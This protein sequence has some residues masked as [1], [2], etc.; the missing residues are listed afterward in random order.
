MSSIAED[1]QN[2]EALGYKQS[3]KRE[4]SNLATI[5]FAF[6]IMGLCSS[7]ATTFNT[8]LLLGGPA[9]VTWCWI[10]GSCMC[11][12]LGSSIAEIVSAFPT[13]GGLYTASAQLCP[14][15]HRAVVGW[16]VGWLNILGQVAGLS[17]TEF[18]LANMIWAAVSITNPNM[19]ITPGKTVGLFTA[20]LFVHGALNSLATRHLALFTRFFVF[21]NLGA[22]VVI[23]IVL[24]AMTKREDMHPAGY[25]FGSEGIVNQTG[26]W[27]NGIAFL[28]G[29]LSVQWTMTDYDAT[30][31]ISE[32][33]RRA[34]YAAPAAIFI[35][36]IGTG[37]LGWILNIVLVLCSGPLENLPGPSDSAFLEIMALRM[38]KPVALFLWVF[39]C[40]T[41]FFVCQTALQACSRT[42]YAFSRD[43][44]LP[45]N[46]YFGHVAKQTHTPLRAIWLTTILSILPG[47][48]DLA[49]PVAADAI[50]ALTAMALD[51][52]Y[53]IPI[54]LRR[55]YANHPEVHFRP[56]PFYMGSGFL[57]WA[58]N[59]MCI[60]WTLFVCVIFSLPNVLPVTKTNMNYA[61]VITAGVVILSGAWYIASAH[62]HY[63]GPTSN[64]SHDPKPISGAGLGPDDDIPNFERDEDDSKSGHVQTYSRELDTKD[65]DLGARASGG[66][67]V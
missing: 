66:R 52:S 51:L 23:V 24:L 67:S 64:I 1:E 13:C 11:F 31:H 4:F 63:H 15:S 10:I 21:I 38:G 34:A 61:S 50:F 44:G 32:E 14:K 2:L 22:T 25:V 28:F 41:A 20:L 8:P 42:V 5:S 3:F 59:V 43:H 6:S 26:G 19:T 39:V 36:V 46:G 17:S 29:L 45:D 37:I 12:T 35:A 58:A 53:I 62:R 47:L 65:G 56:G 55:L 33:V 60:S 27:P 54:F 48:L 16:I 18:G 57:G 30:A 7:V 40:L 49:S 9:S